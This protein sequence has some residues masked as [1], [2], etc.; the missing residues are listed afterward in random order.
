LIGRDDCGS[1]YSAFSEE[2]CATEPKELLGLV[3]QRGG[4]LRQQ[5]FDANMG[6]GQGKLL[7]TEHMVAGGVAKQL[8]QGAE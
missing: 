3:A 4:V 8:I 1:G 7:D 5:G 2:E 6:A